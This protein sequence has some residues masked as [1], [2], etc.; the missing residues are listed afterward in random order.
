MLDD[1]PI[2]ELFS[3]F[4]GHVKVRNLNL[5]TLLPEIK[6]AADSYRAV[7]EGSQRPNGPLTRPELFSYRVGTLDSEVARPLLIWLDDPGQR[8]ISTTDKNRI[9]ELLESWFVR[10]AIVKAPSQGSNRFIVDLMVQL[11]KQPH[12]RLAIETERYLAA[13]KT[14]VGYWPDDRE[15]S[16]ALTGA[17]AYNKYLRVRL[18]M[19]LE[20]LEDDKRGYPNGTRLAMGPIARGTGTIEHLMP[21]QWR[22]NWPADLTADEQT[23]RDK[24]VHELGNLTLVTQSLNSTVSNGS[25]TTKLAYFERIND[26]LLTNEAIRLANPEWSEVEITQR[27]TSLIAAIQRIWQVPVG[28]VGLATAESVMPAIAMTVDVAQLVSEGLVAPGAV[29]LARP[30]VLRGAKAAVGIDG[31]IFVENAPFDTPSAAALAVNSEGLYRGGINGWTF[32]E[33]ESSGRTL[34]EVRLDYLSSLGEDS[35]DDD[36]GEIPDPTDEESPVS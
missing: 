15:V 16:D 20:A 13:N 1:F 30:T 24:I 34:A 31:R 35:P 19:I 3:Q 22:T 12:D 29:L 2:R 33:V 27:T 23:A 9:L 11:S 4:K 8:D 5:S 26:V 6:S 10:R 32:W 14:P 25:W 36:P 21:R 28:H 7:I 17:A 18:R